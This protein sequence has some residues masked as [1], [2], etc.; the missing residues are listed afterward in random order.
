MI[1]MNA[2]ALNDNMAVQEK[3][4]A[5]AIQAIDDKMVLLIIIKDHKFC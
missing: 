3:A 1:D 5:E 2:M 4:L